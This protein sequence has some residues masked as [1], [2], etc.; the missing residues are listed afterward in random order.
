MDLP[1]DAPVT[2]PKAEPE[3]VP[4]AE[5]A[6]RRGLP[7]WAIALI[8][9]FTCWLWIPILAALFAVSIAV[10]LSIAALG[11]GLIAGGAA[12]VI[13]GIWALGVLPDAL[14]MFGCA[15]IALALGLVLLWLGIWLLIRLIGLICRGAKA[16]Y[17]GI[18]KARKEPGL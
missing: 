9:V 16:V 4:E 11:V 1:L 2:A 14:L 8:L 17:R 7:G 3:A 6:A 13:C 15:A 5:G 18:F 12:L 10:S